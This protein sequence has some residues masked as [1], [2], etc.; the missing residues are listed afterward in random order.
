[1]TAAPSTCPRHLF[2][3][4]CPRCQHEQYAAATRPQV[5][6]LVVSGDGRWLERPRVWTTD[7]A[8]AKRYKQRDNASRAAR[9]YWYAT[10]PVTARVEKVLK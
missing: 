8:R 9:S 5:S 6:Y 1:M 10:P 3:D 7:I 4:P 2:R